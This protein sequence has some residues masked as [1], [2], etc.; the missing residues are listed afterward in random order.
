M[1]S[2]RSDNPPHWPMALA[3]ALEIEDFDAPDVVTAIQAAL[4]ASWRSRRTKAA[5]RM[6][7]SASREAGSASCAQ[8]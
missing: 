2:R 1:R 6:P 4:A 3:K 7:W 8:A 5:V